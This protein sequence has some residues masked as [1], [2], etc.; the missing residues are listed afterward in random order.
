MTNDSEKT[1]LPIIR[2]N[3]DLAMKE[4]DEAQARMLM[5]ELWA[6]YPGPATAP[7]ILSAFRSLKDKGTNS[8][9]TPLRVT[10][11]RSFSV[12]PVV[13]ILRA[14]GL[15]AGLDL[16]VNVGDF[17]TYSQDILS[18][19]GSAYTPETDAVIL[20]VQTRDIAPD[21]WRGGDIDSTRVQQVIA[22]FS[23][24]IEAFRSGTNAYLIIHNLE[25]P[26][27]AAAGVLDGQMTHSQRTAIADINAGLVHAAA[28]HKGVH[29]LDYDAL[30][31]RHGRANWSDESRWLTMRLPVTMENLHYLADEWLKF[32]VPI[33]GRLAKALVVDLDNTLW[34]GVLGE[35]GLDGI[36]LDG[37]YPGAAYQ[38]VQQALLDLSRRGIILAVCSKNDEEDALT[39]IREHPGMLLETDNFSAFKI[40]WQDKASNLRAIAE[41]LNIGLDALAFLDD[42]PAERLWVRQNLPEV[43]VIEVSD[44]PLTFATAIRSASVFE[45]LSVSGEDKERNRQYVEQ[46]QRKEL[47]DSITSLEDY[48]RSLDM[49]LEVFPVSAADVPRVAQLTQKT[50]QF[51][52]T[53]RRYNEADITR[54]AADPAYLVLAARVTDRFGDSGIISVVIVEVVDQRARLDTFLMSCR[55]IGRTVETAILAIIAEQLTEKGVV[56][57]V[58][59]FIPTP[60]NAPAKNFLV[61]HGFSE[62]PEGAL[63][64]TLPHPSLKVPDWFKI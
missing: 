44:D 53:T 63:T 18:P 42:N 4:G 59:E 11:L 23:G 28:Q 29:I 5:A 26:A 46:R 12:E 37:E 10:I 9:L 7:L 56:S 40:N 6:T 27:C 36:Q 64:V 57:L 22:E 45:R 8:Q 39:T 15:L 1:T 16:E 49:A 31:S 30:A 52:L 47:Q 25:Q 34:G 35:D 33:S 60:K 13:P 38:A 3:I 14:G 51:N 55:V 58:G 32:L 20:A 21:I 48:Y 2:Q 54:F 24:L 41:E 17:N 61:G 50:N 19:G 62:Q 43:H